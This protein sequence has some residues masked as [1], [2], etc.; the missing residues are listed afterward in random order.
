MQRQK[1]DWSEGHPTLVEREAQPVA[2]QD[3]KGHVIF[4]GQPMQYAGQGWSFYY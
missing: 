1:S 3:T 2:K 4:L